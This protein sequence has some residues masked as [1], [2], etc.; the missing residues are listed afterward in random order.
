MEKGV[1]W[2]LHHHADIEDSRK[3]DPWWRRN[4]TIIEI[5]KKITLS[6]LLRTITELGYTKAWDMRHRGEFSQ[7]GGSISIFPINTK[8]AYNI[9]FDGN[10]IEEI[11]ERVLENAAPSTRVNAVDHDFV[12]GDFVVHIDHGIGILREITAED[13]MELNLDNFSTRTLKP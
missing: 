1:D 13:F 8:H 10:T 2:F 3:S 4:T 7:R 6:E 5:D 11:E 12:V 9:L